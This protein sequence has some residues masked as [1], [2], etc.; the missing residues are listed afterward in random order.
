[1]LFTCAAFLHM[2]YA[3]YENNL[4]CGKRLRFNIVLMNTCPDELNLYLWKDR[5]RSATILTLS[6]KIK[7]PSAWI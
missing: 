6:E 4:S 7:N 2:L 5:S 1:M 3:A